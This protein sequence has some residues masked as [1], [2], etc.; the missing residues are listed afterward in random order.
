MLR[1]DVED[2]QKRYQVRKASFVFIQLPFLNKNFDSIS[3]KC[4]LLFSC[5]QVSGDVRSWSRKYQNLPGLFLGKSKQCRWIDILMHCPGEYSDT[6]LTELRCGKFDFI[7]YCFLGYRKQLQEGQKLG[8]LLRG[9]LPIDYRFVE[10]FSKLCF[11]IWKLCHLSFILLQEAEAK[12]AAAEE[13]ERS[14]N[15][16]L[17]QTLSRINVLEAQ[18]GFYELYKPCFWEYGYFFTNLELNI[19]YRFHVLEPSNPN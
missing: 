10:C 8:Q 16:R 18:V 14:V 13:K 7:C 1:R 2:L 19:F 9:L 12:A 5:R 6:Y 3:Y 4:H 17:S 11:K 15:E